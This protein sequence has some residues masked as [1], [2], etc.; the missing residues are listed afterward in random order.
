MDNIYKN[1]KTPQEFKQFIQNKSVSVVGLGI[2]NIP[3]IEFLARCGVK[4]ISARDRKDIFSNGK[5]PELEN[6]GKT[7]E[8]EYVLGEN[9]LENL[10]E[11]VIFKSPGIRRDLPQFIG[12]VQNGSILT[13]EMELFFM[14]CPASTIAVTGSEGKTTT[15]TIIGEILKASGKTVHVGGNI[16]EPL[17]NKI[18]SIKK[19]D[20]A[21]LELSSFQLFDLDNGSFAPDVAVMTNI[22]PNHLDWHRDMDEYIAAKKI[23]YKNQ[24]EYGRLIVS[25][26]NELTRGLE[27]EGKATKYFFSK[28]ILPRCY[29]NGIYCDGDVIWLRSGGKDTQIL[30]KSEIFVKGAHN[31]LNFMAA[32]GATHDIASA[33][34]IQKTAQTF[35]GVEHRIEF[36]RE[37]G[38]VSYYNSSIDSSPT[39]T[40]AALNYFDE[41]KK[42]VVILGGSEKN[43][44]FEPLAPVVH[45][46]AKAAVLYG[47][48]KGSVK[49]CLEDYKKSVSN[50]EELTVSISD[51]FDAAV[52]KAKELAKAGDVVL[53]SPAC[54]SFDC[55]I[56][57]EERGSRFKE[58]VNNL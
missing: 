16:G 39:R 8:I 24:K 30:K 9:Y 55:F 38:G 11:D 26:D 48:A 34:A 15:T 52:M 31:V 6:L 46:K 41:D 5:I 21:V 54:A 50:R 44:S 45:K 12:A 47:A 20:Y 2:S 28:D 3:L 18:E 29:K 10:R 53:L 49:K 27:N 23:I 25:Y 14:L 51:S 56:N 17:L 22:T 7:L 4:K 57:F 42:I 13:S 37:H 58:L 40:I 32:I 1:I 33:E 43:I 19:D 35:G 36:V